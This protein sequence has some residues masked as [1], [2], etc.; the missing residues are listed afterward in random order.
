M[1]TE[2]TLERDRT[3]RFGPFELSERQAELRKSGVRIKLQEQPFRVLVELVANSGNLLSREDLHKK[4]WPADTF[5]DFDVGLNSAIRKLRQALNDDA[6]NPRYI[7]T[8]AKRGYRFIA[9]V[10]DVV[11]A[12]P[13]TSRD[14]P[15]Q[16]PVSLPDDG[17]SFT[18]GQEIQRNPRPWYW[19]LAAVCVLAL[20]ILLIYGGVTARRRTNTTPLATEQRITANPREAPVTGAVVSRDGKYVAYSDTT[21]VYVRHIDTGET[22]PLQL[23]KGFD[24]VPTSW[25]PD[26]TNLLLSSGETLRGLGASI[27]REFPPCGRCLSWGA[28]H[29]SWLKMPTEEWF[30]RTVPRLRFCVLV[31]RAG[32]KSG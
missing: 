3:F 6:E 18:T 2:P 16:A 11:P 10:A 21:G 27:R 24:V 25:F 17:T 20:L 5:V 1:P 26:G 30:L 14:S 32:R 19:V 23:P 13:P 12:V 31:P 4:L 29:E 8:L 7:E 28:T 9:P 15:A 22:R